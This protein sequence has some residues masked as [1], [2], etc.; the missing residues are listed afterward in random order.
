MFEARA[1]TK[2]DGGGGGDGGGQVAA[3]A[4]DPAPGVASALRQSREALVDIQG[5]LDAL[6]AA[7]R[8]PDAAPDSAAPER[9]RNA[10]RRAGSALAA[11]GATA[12]IR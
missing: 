4:S 6:L 5:Q 2:F 1:E 9:L 7:L 12:G 3:G 11:L 8:T 10:T